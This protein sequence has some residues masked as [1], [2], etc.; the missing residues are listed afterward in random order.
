MINDILEMSKLE[1]GSLMLRE[2]ECYFYEIVDMARDMLA[3]KAH[4]KEL[5]FDFKIDTHV[6]PYICIDEGKLRQVWY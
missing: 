5:L 6:P 4:E 2:K 1:A 3:L